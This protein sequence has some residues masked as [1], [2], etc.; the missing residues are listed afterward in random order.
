MDGKDDDPWRTLQ[1]RPAWH[2]NVRSR[3]PPRR[4]SLVRPSLGWI[5]PFI[6]AERGDA[7]RRAGRANTDRR[8]D[9]GTGRGA[10]WTERGASLSR[11]GNWPARPLSDWFADGFRLLRDCHQSSCSACA[12]E[13]R[14]SHQ[15]LVKIAGG[16]A[17]K[18]KVER[19]RGRACMR[20]TRK[21]SDLLREETMREGTQPTSHV[22]MPLSCV[23]RVASAYVCV[24][25]GGK[26]KNY[27]ANMQQGKRK[28]T[29]NGCGCGLRSAAGLAWR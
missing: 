27:S 20:R 15:K 2:S 9:H 5:H 11:R 26:K 17:R 3:R 22:D 23:V 29:A 4:L 6:L 13:A 18:G 1:T 12:R 25:D 8:G 19:W 10:T 28:G 14:C 21:E 24:Y 7:S 16:K